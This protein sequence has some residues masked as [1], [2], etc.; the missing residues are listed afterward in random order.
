[1]MRHQLRIEA[2][3]EEVLRAL[4]LVDEVHTQPDGPLTIVELPEGV[5]TVRA[6]GT[7]TTVQIFD[8]DSGVHVAGMVAALRSAGLWVNHRDDQ[9]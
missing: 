9:R 8:E 3:I 7:G 2:P 5:G 4:D 1:M 6:V